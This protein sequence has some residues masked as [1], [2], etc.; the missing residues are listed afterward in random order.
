[1][2]DDQWPSSF[3]HV[4]RLGDTARPSGG[5][6]TILA[7]VD[8]DERSFVALRTAVRTADEA[9]SELFALH[10]CSYQLPAQA[11][12]EREWADSVAESIGQ[13]LL[14]LP[15][16]PLRA[17]V[18]IAVHRG[19]VPNLLSRLRRLVEPDVIM[20]GWP[21]SDW[22]PRG[23]LSSL[24]HGLGCPLMLLPSMAAQQTAEAGSAFPQF[25]VL[26]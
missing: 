24:C 18:T 1:M 3:F 7:L 6:R 15:D 9:G 26:Q 4:R 10:L 11:L 16:R 2:H 20:A 25:G 5:R 23:L 19:S 8:L 22:N 17:G 14:A 21:A 12:I 13:M